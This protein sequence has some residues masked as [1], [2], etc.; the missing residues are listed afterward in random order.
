MKT[1]EGS[2]N[3]NVL[4]QCLLNIFD[5]LAAK[6]YYI[7]VLFQNEHG[8]VRASPEF[9]V[10][11]TIG[12]F[13]SVL[14]SLY[15]SKNG[16]LLDNS[17]NFILR[18][19]SEDEI[20]ILF[21]TNS[22][23]SVHSRAKKSFLGVKLNDLFESY[24]QSVNHKAGCVKLPDPM[25]EICMNKDKLPLFNKEAMCFIPEIDL[26]PIVLVSR[27]LQYVYHYPDVHESHLE[28]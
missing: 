10:P 11:R 7:E 12:V 6:K 18:I 9:R 17:K 4:H 15:K 14:R 27:I 23:L 5:S 24:W 2:N 8:W 22:I 16:V 13:E 3:L 25:I 26:I 19:A 1:D 21:N 28:E 20:T